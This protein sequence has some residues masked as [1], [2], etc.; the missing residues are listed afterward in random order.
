MNQNNQLRIK[1][2]KYLQ[3]Y[4]V[5]LIGQSKDWM[6]DYL[7]SR[8][9]SAGCNFQSGIHTVP[10]ENN[11]QAICG[12]LHST[13]GTAIQ[14]EPY[15]SR[16][17]VL[18]RFSLRPLRILIQNLRSSVL[19]IL[20][21]ATYHT[22]FPS[23]R[24]RGKHRQ[25]ALQYFLHICPKHL[26]PSSRHCLHKCLYQ[27]CIPTS[28]TFRLGMIRLATRFLEIGNREVGHIIDDLAVREVHSCLVTA[29]ERV[30]DDHSERCRAAIRKL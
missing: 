4:T 22:P 19:L 25:V 5:V 20:L 23:T 24:F 7:F 12:Y 1:K 30:E 2:I 10:G 15:W 9:P 18:Q 8:L 11:R 16:I 17:S 26:L 3:S 28:M 27:P 14:T 6:E 21:H 13:A 29:H